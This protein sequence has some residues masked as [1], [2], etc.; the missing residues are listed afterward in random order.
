M[1]MSVLIRGM[2][3]PKNCKQCS[4]YLQSMD[5]ERNVYEICAVTAKSYNWGLTTRPSDCPLTP[6]PPH[7]R[8]IDADA[9]VDKHFGKAYLAK[10]ITAS[11]DEMGTAL[12]NIPLVINNA[13]TIIPA[14]DGE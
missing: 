12:V 14:E 9:L 1:S 7:G 11:K 10:V 3:M 2:E 5:S 8:L 6:V 4:L 13:R